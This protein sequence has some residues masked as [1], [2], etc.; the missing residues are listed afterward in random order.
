MIWSAIYVEVRKRGSGLSHVRFLLCTCVDK[1]SIPRQVKAESSPILFCPVDWESPKV[2]TLSLS[3]N[4]LQLLWSAFVWVGVQD[5]VAS[6]R[7]SSFLVLILSFLAMNES[8]S[9]ILPK[10]QT[11]RPGVQHHTTNYCLSHY[12]ITR[13]KV[14]NTIDTMLFQTSSWLFLFHNIH[15][16]LCLF[17]CIWSFLFYIRGDA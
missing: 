11:S 16:K 6:R 5:Y 17:L 12:F 10:Q 9:Q 3:S 8:L 15:S 13:E 7:S 2:L 1:Q 4:S 14:F